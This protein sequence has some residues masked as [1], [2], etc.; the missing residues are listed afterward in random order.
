VTA[1]AVRALSESFRGPVLA[2]DHPEFD[3]A[4]QVFQLAARGRPSVV[5]RPLDSEDVASAIACAREHGLEIAVRAG[6]HSVAGHSTGEGVMVL[7]LRLL[8]DLTVDAAARRLRAGAG[9]TA[10]EVVAAAHAHGLTVPFG[11]TSTVGVAGITLGGGIGYL[12]RKEGMTIDRLVSVDLVTADGRVVTASADSEPELF[13]ALR[14]GGG[15]FG[16]ATAFEYDLVDA[17]V[18]YGGGLLL[19]ATWNVLRGIAPLAAA[20]PE[21]LTVIANYMPAPPAPFVP[22]SMV[23]RPIVAVLGA[24]AGDLANGESAWAPFRALGEPVADIVG[25]MP[26]PAIYKFTER[27]AAPAPSVNRSIL[28]ET[29]DDEVIE[30]LRDAYASSPGVMTLIQIRVLGGAMARVPSDATAFAHREAPVAIVALTA[31]ESP[32]EMGPALRWGDHVL[33]GLRPKGIGAYSNFLEEEG[34][35]RIREAYPAS[36]YRRLAAAKAAWDPDNVFHRNQNIRP[37]S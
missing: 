33:A 6:G 25:P 12:T 27:A 4:A 34:E 24:F 10:G 21:E 3:G 35:A 14:G 36:T 5:V 28:L 15:N 32:A 37:A 29:V 19:P 1:A 23:G 22:A 18:V 7:D 30:A 9:L 13:W 2:P 16:V 17:G 26:Y 11:D 31:A 8:R 20:A